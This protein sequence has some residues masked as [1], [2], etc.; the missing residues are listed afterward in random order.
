MPRSVNSETWLRHR[1]ERGPAPYGP[2]AERCPSTLS[3]PGEL[4][5]T[6]PAIVPARAHTRSSG[7]TPLSMTG[8]ATAETGPS[9]RT[10]ISGHEG[11]RVSQAQPI[12]PPRCSV[13]NIGDDLLARVP[14]DGLG[15][16][17]TRTAAGSHPAISGDRLPSHHRRAKVRR[18]SSSTSHW[19]PRSSPSPIGS[20]G[21]KGA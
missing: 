4:R 21:K 17:R 5:R 10:L 1:R 9:A 3:A 13:K 7:H 18:C 8:R 12:A 11:R 6:F 16:R 2:V 20:S 14:S 15:S 19:S